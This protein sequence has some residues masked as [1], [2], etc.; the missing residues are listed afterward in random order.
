MRHSRRNGHQQA[1]GR[2]QRS[3]QAARRHQA[4]HPVGQQG[5]FRVGQHND[6]G[7]HFELIALPASSSGF[8]GSGFVLG[9]VV[10]VLNAAVTILVSELQ[11]TCFFPALHP[12][13]L[14]V[15]LQTGFRGIQ[16]TPCIHGRIDG[17]MQVQLGHGRHRR[18]G[19][20]QNGNEHQRPTSA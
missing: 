20:V 4:N 14:R 19:G 12:V 7:V 6:V 10:V 3:R 17:G 13:R 16:I 18:C 15:S 2:G 9:L 11:Q 8:G 1:S 5:D